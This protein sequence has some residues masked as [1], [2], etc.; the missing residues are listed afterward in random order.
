MSTFYNPTPTNFYD[1]YIA[2]HGILGMKW[3]KQNGPPYP[4][5]SG[6]HSKSEKSAGWKKSLGGGRNEEMYD[7]KKKFKAA[8]KVATIPK[9]ESN[10]NKSTEDW[11]KSN[12]I[13]QTTNQKANS[14]AL[15]NA[16]DRESLIKEYENN[17]CKNVT[18]DIWTFNGK[19]A[20]AVGYE[21]DGKY[22]L[23]SNQ[24]GGEAK[25]VLNISRYGSKY[26]N[27]YGSTPEGKKLLKDW[28][29]AEDA[30]DDP[31]YDKN[32]INKKEK[33]LNAEANYAF[34]KMIADIGKDEFI[35]A[36][37]A[38][39]KSNR[40]KSFEELKKDWIYSQVMNQYY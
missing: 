24:N 34:D 29:K 12:T 6:D 13:K 4:L 17:G 28:M 2:H 36:E 18:A 9:K 30:S 11:N 20:A 33:Y 1:D 21:K 38:F 35:K 23:E 27:Q 8:N 37:T 25:K 31:W 16:K 39:N 7:R 10:S 26:L 5:G 3:G 22:Y 15:A 32:V 19:K 40:N 14:K